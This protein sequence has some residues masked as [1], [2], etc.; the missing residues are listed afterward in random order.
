MTINYGLELVLTMIRMLAK[1]VLVIEDGMRCL[2]SIVVDGVGFSAITEIVF[3]DSVC[4]ALA[5]SDLKLVVTTKHLLLL[6]DFNATLSVPQLLFVHLGATLGPLPLMLNLL[7]AF[8]G[9]TCLL[10]KP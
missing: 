1:V 7:N 10:L 4:H 6:L 3:V 5:I 9:L 8:L 2:L